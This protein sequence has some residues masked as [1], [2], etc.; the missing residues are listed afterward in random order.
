MAKRRIEDKK[1]V[2]LVKAMRVTPTP[3]IDLV[4][5]VRLRTRCT[6]G[7]ARAAILAGA[8]TV[9]GQPIGFV[10]VDDKAKKDNKIKVLTQYVR[11]DLRDRI[12]VVNPSDS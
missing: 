1:R 2:R 5:Y 3:L 9:D 7:R 10:E 8:L 6:A 11:A 12:V 4:D